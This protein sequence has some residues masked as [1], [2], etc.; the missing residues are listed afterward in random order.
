MPSSNNMSGEEITIT[1]VAL[2]WT[3]MG[4]KMFNVWF[5]REDG[6][7]WTMRHWADD[8][9]DAYVKAIRKVEGAE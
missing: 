3:D 2:A 9:L 8:E 6:T 4:Q 1:K 7:Q 5:T